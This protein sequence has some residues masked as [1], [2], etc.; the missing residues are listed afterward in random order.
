MI[1]RFGIFFLTA[2]ISAVFSVSSALAQQVPIRIIVFGD[3]LTSGY[4]ISP[5][6][7]FDSILEQKFLS[8]GYRVDVINLSRAGETTTGAVS[9]LEEVY[10]AEPDVVLLQLGFNDSVQGIDPAKII[11]KNMHEILFRLRLKDV[12]IM[13]LGTKPSEQRDNAYKRVYNYVIR[14]TA[15]HNNV[16]HYP[17]IMKNVSSRADL[18]LA[19]GI[20]PNENGVLTMVHNIYPFVKRLVQWRINL[21]NHEKAVK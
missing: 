9:R 12:G 11:Y 8:E 5:E 21:Q 1:K 18:T 20:H 10:A 7:S 3:S 4:R 6:K 17:D 15:K 19:D 13:V 16:T 2:A 14:K